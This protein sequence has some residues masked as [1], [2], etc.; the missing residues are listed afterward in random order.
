MLLEAEVLRNRLRLIIELGGPDDDGCVLWF[1]D[2]LEALDLGCV[3]VVVISL[4]IEVRP[5]SELALQLPLDEWGSS[6]L[7]SPV[8]RCRRRAVGSRIF[9][10]C[11][12]LTLPDWVTATV[13]IP[14]LNGKLRSDEE[15]DGFRSCESR[16]SFSFIFFCRLLIASKT[17]KSSISSAFGLYLKLLR[18]VSSLVPLNRLIILKRLLPHCFRELKWD[19]ERFTSAANESFFNTSLDL[20]R[21]TI[22]ISFSRLADISSSSAWLKI[23]YYG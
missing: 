19:D 5:D 15:Y 10:A 13:G 2:E 14:V 7:A 11:E 4:P 16:R 20:L 18:V 23:N 6:L 9:T 12:K 21:G 1:S 8:R 22:V 3:V 17:L